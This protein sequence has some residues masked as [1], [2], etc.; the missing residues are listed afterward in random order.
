MARRE[1]GCEGSVGHA[2][3]TPGSGIDLRQHLVD[4]RGDAS[5]QL[6][7]TPEVARG[8]TSRERT[9]TRQRDLEPGREGLDGDQHG[10]ELP[11]LGREIMFEDVSSGTSRLRLTA[12]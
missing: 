8:T 2:D 3:A 12:A 6:F 4:G 1:P 5:R 7:V 9:R 10:F 11:R